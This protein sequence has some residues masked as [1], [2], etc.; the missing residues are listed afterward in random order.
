[1]A[2]DH[3]P[4]HTRRGTRPGGPIA[5]LLFGILFVRT[6]K[7]RRVDEVHEHTPRFPWDGCRQLLAAPDPRSDLPLLEVKDIVYADDLSVCS[8]C[9]AAK[10]IGKITCSATGQVFDAFSGSGFVV[11]LGPT[12]TAAVIMPH[13]AGSRAARQTLYCKKLGM[14]PILREHNG[15]VSLPLVHQYKHLGSMLPHNGSMFPEVHRRLNL[16]RAAFKEGKRAVFACRAIPVERRVVLFQGRV[17]SVLLFGAGGWP[18]LCAKEYQDFAGGYISLCRQLLAIPRSADS[19]WSESQILFGVGLPGPLICLRVERLR[20]L[21]L[22]VRTAPD[23]LW[24]VI[25]Q[26]PTFLSAQL[27]ALCWLQTG[28][29]HVAGMPDPAESWEAWVGLIRT[30]P[31]RY[32]GLIRRAAML[33]VCRSLARAAWDSCI[34]GIWLSAKERDVS[35]GGESVVH[36]CLACKLSFPTLQTWGAHAARCHGYHSRAQLLTLGN[37]CQACW[38]RYASSAKLT[39][40]LKVSPN[41]LGFIEGLSREGKLQAMCE[42]E[43]HAQAPTCIPEVRPCLPAAGPEICYDLLQKLCE[44]DILSD[45]DALAVVT[46]FVQ[47]LPV[48]VETVRQAQGAEGW[49]P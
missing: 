29:G 32:K 36:G 23:T 11:N 3:Q 1:M 5:D 31:G 24:A 46:A 16:A 41:C 6:L 7:R 18:T 33:E 8:V 48:L 21:T 14:L 49:H 12:K 2:Q 27:D 20:F 26:D 25:R 9:S 37:Q 43:G 35:Q 38:R 30:S 22:L 17:L 4:V 47:P 45:V 28:S 40:H 10:D 13:G 15:S 19:H 34:R 39:L 44:G 42:V